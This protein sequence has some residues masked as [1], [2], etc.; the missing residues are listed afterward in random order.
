MYHHPA[1]RRYWFLTQLLTLALL[2]LWLLLSVGLPL[3]AEQLNQFTLFSFPLGFLLS[4]QFTV[5]AYILILICYAGVMERLDHR[6]RVA[7]EEDE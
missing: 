3:W 5:I 6:F 7:E 2:L 1:L 4:A